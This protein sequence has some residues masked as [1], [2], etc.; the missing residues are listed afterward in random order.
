MDS[1]PKRER[2]SSGAEVAVVLVSIGKEWYNT[3]NNNEIAWP[4]VFW[5]L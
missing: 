3:G 2:L 4:W 1:E 5:I